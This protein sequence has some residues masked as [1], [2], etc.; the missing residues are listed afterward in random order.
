MGKRCGSALAED[1]HA[2]G[3]L[4]C[5]AGLCPLMAA[6]SCLGMRWYAGT[7]HV[8]TLR[9][10]GPPCMADTSETWACKGR[11]ACFA[12]LSTKTLHNMHL[13]SH[14][15]SPCHQLPCMG[16]ARHLIPNACHGMPAPQNR[17]AQHRM[18]CT[19]AQGPACS[20]EEREEVSPLVNSPVFGSLLGVGACLRV[21][22]PLEGSACWVN[23][24]TTRVALPLQPARSRPATHRPLVRA[25]RPGLL[26]HAPDAVLKLVT[27]RP[28]AVCLLISL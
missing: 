3:P 18:P 24:R 4:A 27:C 12:C 21:A 20:H 7:M 25:C 8:V 11:A 26:F 14:V 5:C 15:P 1:G 2:G 9:D 22:R 10:T 23:T 28:P 17:P 19:Q 13:L 6:R 16:T